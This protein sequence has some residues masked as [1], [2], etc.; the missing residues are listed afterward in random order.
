MK[1]LIFLLFVTSIIIVSFLSIKQ[2]EYLQFQ[3]F[4]NVDQQEEWQINVESGAHQKNKSENF[5]LL[6]AAALEAEVN[7]QRISYE[8]DERNKDKVVYYVVLFDPEQYFEKL[9]L[10]SGRFLDVNSGSEEFLS[11]VQTNHKDQ[12]GKLEIFRSFDPIEIRP[13]SAAEKTRDIKGTYTVSG[14]KNADK[15]KNKLADYGFTVDVSREQGHSLMTHYPYQDMLNKASVILYLLILLALLYD[16]TINYKDIAVRMMFGHNFWQI[17]SYLLRK[18][19]KIFLLSLTIGFLGLLFYLYFYNQFQELS[20]FL[21]FWLKN[22]IPFIIIITVIFIATWIGTKSIHISQMIKNKKPIKLLF[23]LNIAVRF[24]I[25]IFLVLGLQQALSTLFGLKNTVDTQEKWS[26]LKDYSYLGVIANN[27]PGLFRFLEE[28]KQRE[29]FQQFYK[30]LESQGAFFISPSAYYLNG[31]S[32]MPL[33]PNPWGMDGMKV[34]INKNYL[35]INPIFDT[36]N[37]QVVFSDHV[38]KNVITVLVPIKFKEH[39]S[40]IKASIIN[41]YKGIYHLKEEESV[42]VDILYVQNEQ[43]YFTF[44]TNMAEDKH[45]EILDPIAVI[46]NHEFDPLILANHISMGYG[47]YTKN[48]GNEHPF[49]MTQDTLTKYGLEEIWQPISVA[50]S[51]V[52]LKLANDKEVLQL[53]TAYCALFL[54]LGILLLFFSSMYYLEINK[55]VL[56]LQWIFGYSFFEKHSFV[57]LV[58][59]VF[60]NFVFMI[61]FFIASD[62]LLLIKITIGLAIFDLFLVSLILSLKEYRTTKQILIDK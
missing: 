61:C 46:V 53:S 2:F 32:D 12:V 23:L 17:G 13:M 24:I 16:V 47:Y 9:K 22:M 60:W 44:S 7:L 6:K 14:K 48:S 38:E 27:D 21:V 55:Q 37:K 49:A 59:L 41:D 4:N 36:N 29:Q 25:S 62:T 34:E 56:A 3:S 5:Q 50:Y 58:L 45:Y 1:K 15:L 40:E 42:L 35:S 18:Y 26:L 33:N 11:T 20:L 54:L 31:S 43:S 8:R 10:K 51:S 57:Y 28:E 39:E 52:E 19:M 30:E